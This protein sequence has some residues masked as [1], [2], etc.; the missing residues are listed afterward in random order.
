[1]NLA[2]DLNVDSLDMVLVVE[3][4]E[5]EFNVNISNEDLYKIRTVND[6]EN[7]IKALQAVK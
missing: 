5:N 2:S 7:K 1:M 4:I 3:T 6:L